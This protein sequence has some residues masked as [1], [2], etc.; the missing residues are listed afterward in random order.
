[1]AI[2]LGVLTHVGMGVCLM[3][4]SRSNSRGWA[5]AHP[6]T[7]GLYETPVP[8]DLEQ[9]NSNG[10]NSGTNTQQRNKQAVGG[11]LRDMP[12]SGLQVVTRCASCTHMDRSPLLYVHVGLPVQPTKSAWWP[13]PLTFWSRK[14][15]PSHV[16]CG[17]HLC[18]FWSF[19]ASLF[20]T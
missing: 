11:G 14:W 2:A 16:W 17:L 18:Q 7:L 9:P 10:K 12:R 3:G 15:Y 13:W 5:Q 4:Q 6:K 1:M 8:F 19:L 20:S